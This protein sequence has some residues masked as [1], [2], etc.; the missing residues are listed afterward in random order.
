MS[1][2]K[3]YKMKRFMYAVM[4]LLGLSIMFS[5]CGGSNQW[6]EEAVTYMQA[7]V[8]EDGD[9]YPADS[10]MDEVEEIL[11]DLGAPEFKSGQHAVEVIVD[12]YGSEQSYIVWMQDK[13]VM[14]FEMTGKVNAG[15]ISRVIYPDLIE[16][17]WR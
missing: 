1:H 16:K 5:G 13:E 2:Q 4:L 3:N 15:R 17:G 14:Y 9:W 6:Q 8:F 10:D 7:R 12:L 11:V